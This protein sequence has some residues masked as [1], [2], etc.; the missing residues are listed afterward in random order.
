[1]MKSLSK[2]TVVEDGVIIIVD[3][4]PVRISLSMQEKFS[5]ATKLMSH[6]IVEMRNKNAHEAL[7]KGAGAGAVYEE[8]EEAK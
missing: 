5:L 1:M 3:G 8:E 2:V 4:A 6:G 7:I